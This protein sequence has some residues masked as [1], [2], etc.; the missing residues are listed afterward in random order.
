MEW[1]A[2]LIKT[3]KHITAGQIISLTARFQQEYVTVEIPGASVLLK[4]KKF[5][6]K[7]VVTDDSRSHD[8]LSALPTA[9]SVLSVWH[10][11]YSSAP[12]ESG[13]GLP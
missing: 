2:E 10:F 4:L 8:S 3:R 7:T 12:V 9:I 11:P 1:C 6:N 13:R 5:I